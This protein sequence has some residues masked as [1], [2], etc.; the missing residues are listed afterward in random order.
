M[1]IEENNDYQYFL[2]SNTVSKFL[3]PQVQKT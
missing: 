2:F 3:F 1:E